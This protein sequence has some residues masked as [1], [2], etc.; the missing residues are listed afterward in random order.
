MLCTFWSNQFILL[1]SRLLRLP[2]PK[3]STSKQ[4]PLLR[5]AVEEVVHHNHISRR[6]SRRVSVSKVLH[7]NVPQSH[8]N[9]VDR[10]HQTSTS[11]NSE[12][13]K[14]QPSVASSRENTVNQT[15][16]LVKVF[17]VRLVFGIHIDENCT[18]ASHGP[19]LVAAGNAEDASEDVGEK[20]GEQ[21]RRG[22]RLELCGHTT[23]KNG[24]EA[25]V[26]RI[27][28]VGYTELATLCA[29]HEAAWGY[30]VEEISREN[31]GEGGVIPVDLRELGDDETR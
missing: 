14:A 26:G 20:R 10:R 9:A 12:S 18:K 7:R 22:E 19:C 4:N 25:I 24:V 29:H 11:T 15:S 6:V 3:V 17:N 30:C 16:L 5:L 27:F 28:R 23:R 1:S 8:T 31:E 13:N 2:V 21:T